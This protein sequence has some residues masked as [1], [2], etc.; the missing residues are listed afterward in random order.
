MAK[1]YGDIFQNNPPPLLYHYSSWEGLLGIINSRGL[2]ASNCRSL[3]DN[4]ELSH[5]MDVLL[6]AFENHFYQ[7]G[8]KG[9][10][11]IHN[12]QQ[13]LKNIGRK[14]SGHCVFSLSE[15][16]DLLSQWRAYAQDGRGGSIG[17]NSTLLKNDIT[18]SGFSLGRCLYDHGIQYKIC[19]DFLKN[20][21]MGIDLS[22]LNDNF[23]DEL[24][25]KIEDFL[26]SVGIFLKHPAYVDER[27]WRIVSGKNHLYSDKW[28]FRAT[29][30]GLSSYIEIPIPS[31][32][33]TETAIEDKKNQPH[34]Q[35]TLGPKAR[36]MPTAQILQAISH[37]ILGKGYGV[38]I[39]CAPYIE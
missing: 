9:S 3:N 16:G 14:Q 29:I 28:K 6:H 8:L 5:V 20:A 35:F 15:S 25:E 31:I 34:F 13:N 18:K 26:Y 19:F 10:K 21:L 24:N 36:N 11:N 7:A 30:R 39:S 27:E 22:S 23:P 32:F 4:A 33:S 1:L 2:W 37:K 17:L 38:T 12:I